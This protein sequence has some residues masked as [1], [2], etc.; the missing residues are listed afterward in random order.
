MRK[1]NSPS[2]SHSHSPTIYFKCAFHSIILIP[3]RLLNYTI[4]IFQRN[5]IM[6]VFNRIHI[7]AEMI[8]LFIYL[9]SDVDIITVRDTF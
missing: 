7:S 8:P 3:L 2:V 1:S 9:N 6:T 4:K 5:E